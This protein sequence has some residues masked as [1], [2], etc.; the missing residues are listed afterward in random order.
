MVRWVRKISRDVGMKEGK[1]WKITINSELL[2]TCVQLKTGTVIW[3][4]IFIYENRTTL[5]ID[6]E[7][8]SFTCWIKKS[9][10]LILYI[11]QFY[12]LLASDF[13]QFS[14]LLCDDIPD[15][16]H[17]IASLVHTSSPI[18]IAMSLEIINLAIN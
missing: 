8:Y 5:H 12:T 4:F 1:V 11:K 9:W 13:P 7:N 15:I 14:T 6:I 10:C 2:Q 17:L 16:K 3:L 18:Y